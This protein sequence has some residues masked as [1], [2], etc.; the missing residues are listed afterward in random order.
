MSFKDHFSERSSEYA[1][2]RP[3]YPD[4][5][6][7][8]LARLAPTHGAVWDVGTGNGQAALG[9][10]K[11]FDAV[12]ATDASAAQLAEA[13]P[14]PRVTYRQ[15][16]ESASGLPDRS[17]VLVTVAQAAH[18]FDLERFYREVFRVLKPEGVLAMWCYGMCRIAPEIDPLLSHF[19]HDI[20]GPFWPPERRQVE[21]EYRDLEF[22]FPELPFPQLAMQLEWTLADLIAYL[23]TW[24]AV[25]GYQKSERRDPVP[26]AASGLGRV[27]GDPDHPRL[28]RW[29]LSGRIGRLPS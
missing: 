17:V 29:P 18:W 11:Q 15:G 3:T 28:I 23:R 25:Q 26:A 13:P 12:L 10:A 19:Y 22:P 1:R 21:T 2:A 24:S 4:E 14:H 7:E 20:V 9:L 5:L 16:D 27:W 8:T 6:F